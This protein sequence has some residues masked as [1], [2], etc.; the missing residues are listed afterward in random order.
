[1][2]AK[3]LTNT[4]YSL[5]VH[6]LVL[7]KICRYFLIMFLFFTFFL[8][9]ILRTVLIL[10]F[11][12]SSRWMLEHH[13]ETLREICDIFDFSLRLLCLNGIETLSRLLEKILELLILYFSS[14]WEAFLMFSVL[15]QRLLKWPRP[16]PNCHPSIHFLNL[17]YY[18]GAKARV[19][20]EEFGSLLQLPNPIKTIY[21]NPVS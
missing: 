2:F 17:L 10:I 9:Y 6:Y 16:C 3:C 7:Q 14:A 19:H 1:M 13:W 4:S 18:C 5:S 11:T 12:H 21:F 20:P 8:K 15:M